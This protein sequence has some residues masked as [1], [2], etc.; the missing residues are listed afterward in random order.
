MSDTK[1]Q[2]MDIAR[3]R[4]VVMPAL[5]IS[6]IVGTVLA[7]INH[8]GALLNLDLDADRVVKIGLTYLVPYCVST[9]SSVRAIQ[10]HEFNSG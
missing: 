4:P 3:S 10:G 8:G 1:L 7:L 9:Y 5:R 2:F 6:L